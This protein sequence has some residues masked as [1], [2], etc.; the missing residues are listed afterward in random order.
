MALPSL[1][2]TETFTYGD[3]L[4]WY[5]DERWELIE[6]IAYN[7]TPAPSR[8]HQE[9]LRELLL[10][11]ANFLAN[12]PGEVYCA[13]FDVRLPEE[14]ELDEDIKSVVQPDIVIVCDDSKLDDRGCRGAPDIVVEILSPHTASKDMQKKLLLYEKHKVKEYW[15]VHPAENIIS[16][17]KLDEN[18][19]Y[20]KPDVFTKDNK[21]KTPILEGLEIDFGLVFQQ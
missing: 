21:L 19:N 1:T 8:K 13:P 14:N 20:G 6:G 18:G 12:K 9:I 16:V 17:F 4:N 7:I 5:D 11:I 15:I 2:K 10:Q 3:Y